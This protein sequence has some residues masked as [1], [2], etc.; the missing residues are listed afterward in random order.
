VTPV[1]DVE[2]DEA[3]ARLAS[4]A[5]PALFESVAGAPRR[6][7]LLAFDPLPP[8][9]PATLSGLRPYVGGLERL[10]GDDL[11]KETWFAG[12]FLGALSYDLGVE[13][14]ELDLPRDP[15]ALPPVMGGLYVDHL[16]RDPRARRTWLVLGD[17]PGDGRPAVADRRER[18]LAELARPAPEPTY[19]P[20]G[21]LRR[22]V[23]ATEHRARVERVRA[24]IARGEIYQANLSYRLERAVEGAPHELYRVLRRLHPGP[25]LGYLRAGDA[26]ILSGSPELLLEFT[27]GSGA[28]PAHALTRPIKGTAPRGDDPEEDRARARELLASEKDLAELAMIVDL[29]RNDLGRVAE[30][31]GVDVPAFPRLESY[32]TV[33]HLVADVEARVAPGRDALDV[34]ASVYPGGSVTG[35]PK[36]RS[37]EVIAELEGEG[38]GHA[39]GSLCMLDTNGR[40]RANLLIRTILWRAR[41]DL[42]PGRGE[43]T[44][45]VGGGITWGSDAALEDAECTFKGEALA[46]AT[47]GATEGLEAHAPA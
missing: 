27:P 38:R 34:L 47:E 30:P 2:L 20:R 43:V 11:P 5:A 14:E 26:A 17:E 16:V 3:L 41:P 9:P 29:E 46:I 33:H 6:F 32:A 40:L 18:I 45:R 4:H 42:G 28:S 13:G 24:E 1:P 12:G 35:A 25:Y 10:P 31:A 23:G 8:P 22:L 44:Y 7:D 19:A 36:L 21:P 15:W 39:Y 37:M